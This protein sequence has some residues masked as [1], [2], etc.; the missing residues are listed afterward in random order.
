GG[1]AK[2][3]RWKEHLQDAA[4]LLS[5]DEPLARLLASEEL[6]GEAIEASGAEDDGQVEREVAGLRAGRI[7]P[8]SGAPVVECEQRGERQ[9]QQR[10]DGVDYAGRNHQRLAF[11]PSWRRNPPRS[12]GSC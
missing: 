1:Q 4:K 11:L 2:G 10:D 5:R 8:H 3:E 6:S 9:Q 7:P 12:S